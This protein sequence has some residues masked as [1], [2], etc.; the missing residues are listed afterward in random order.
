MKKTWY[1]VCGVLIFIGVFYLIYQN[2]S[3]DD[4]KKTINVYFDD[5]AVSVVGDTNYT[6]PTIDN[7]VMNNYFINFNKK[8]DSINYEF[9]VVNDGN[10]SMKLADMV[11]DFSYDKSQ[12]QYELSYLDGSVVKKG[13]VLAPNTSK[14]M[15]L[16]YSNLS[17]REI[18]LRNLGLYLIYNEL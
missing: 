10:V 3:S 18:E 1:I 12:V 14:R 9:T 8:N 15:I 17:D 6:K 5:L 7:T 2:T 16:K 4:L 11:Y 13:D